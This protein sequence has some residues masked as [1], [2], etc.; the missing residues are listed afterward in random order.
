MC[1]PA[2]ANRPSPSNAST[3]SSPSPNRL[4]LTYGSDRP[5]N[6]RAESSRRSLFWTSV[7]RAH[8]AV[9]IFGRNSSRHSI[10]STSSA[11]DAAT[12]D[13]RNGKRSMSPSAVTPVS[14]RMV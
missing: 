6:D 12:R 4:L 11:I 8:A 2:E 5:R 9:S 7:L 1:S 13:G 14:T 3:A 10:M